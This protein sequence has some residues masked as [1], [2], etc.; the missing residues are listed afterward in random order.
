MKLLVICPFGSTEPFGRENLEKVARPGTEF[1]YE[2]VK[3]VFPLPYN[4]FPYNMLKCINA[5]VERTI[6]AEQQGYDAVVNSCVSDPGLFEMR[7]VVDIPVT[8]CFESATHLAATMGARWS[9]VTVEELVAK[10]FD[11]LLVDLY[12]VRQSMAS[13]R[14]IGIRANQLYPE[15]T[16]TEEVA[17]RLVEVAKKCIKEDGAEVI[18]SGCTILSSLFTSYFKADPVDV[19]G[20]PV[21][22]PMYTAFKFAEMMVDLK[23]LAGYPA[24]SRAGLC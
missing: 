15:I 1:D 24:V 17:N 5:T 8:G 2:C 3:D 18:I 20:A 16:P 7:A 19:I 4:T 21:I 9:V 11:K 10:R 6:L 14:H 13:I 22:D 23:D 12:G